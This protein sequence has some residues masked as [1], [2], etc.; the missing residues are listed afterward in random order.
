LKAR[1]AAKY[2]GLVCFLTLMAKPTS[3]PPELRIDSNMR[4]RS[5]ERAGLLEFFIRGGRYDHL[6]AHQLDQLKREDRNAARAKREHSVACLELCIADQCAPC[7]EAGRGER[8][9]L[10]MTVTARRSR[11]PGARTHHNFTR[12]AIDAVAGHGREIAES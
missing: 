8:R 5:A 1:Y 2:L 10:G 4:L 7:G 3:Q 11:E 6:G 12:V 9:C